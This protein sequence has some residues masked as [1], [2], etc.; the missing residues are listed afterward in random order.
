[1]VEQPFYTRKA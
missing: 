1:L